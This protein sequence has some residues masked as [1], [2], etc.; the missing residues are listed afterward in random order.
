V[1]TISSLIEAIQNKISFAG[2]QLKKCLEY[3]RKLPESSRNFPFV[4]RKGKW[5]WADKWSNGFFIGQLL[6][7]YQLDGNPWWIEEADRHIDALKIYRHRGDFQDI[8]YILYYSYALGY[9]IT[10]NSHYRDI[11]LEGADSLFEAMMEGG[12]LKCKWLEDGEHYAG[13]DSLMNIQ[14]WLW[15]YRET[16]IAAYRESALRCIRHAI[17]VLVRPDGATYEYVRVD[18]RSGEWIESFNKNAARPDSV[19]A[20]GQAW[21]IYGLIQAY[22][23]LGESS[24][25]PVIENLTEYYARHAHTDLI[26]CWDLLM[27][28]S[29]TLVDASAASVIAS[30]LLQYAPISPDSKYAKWGESL[31][32]RLLSPE[33]QPNPE[34][35]HEGILLHASTPLSVVSTPGE[36]QSWGDYFLL[37]AMYSYRSGR[38]EK[39]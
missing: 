30:A 1:I 29:D 35:G 13:I 36:S 38:S 27:R 39:L 34:K 15:A 8:G 24:I 9:T 6:C 23:V 11:A 18:P 33:Y 5:V 17:R 14:L 16:G 21:A 3:R 26:P 20:R 22:L 2:E 31:L 32:E 19:W 37:E 25:I 10:G 7:M 12:Y 4:T 28:D